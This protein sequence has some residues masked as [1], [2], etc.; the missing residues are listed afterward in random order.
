METANKTYQH[1]DYL[2]DDNQ[3]ASLEGDEVALL[4]YRSN[5]LGSDLT[6]YQLRR[7]QYQLQNYRTRSS[8]PAGHRSNVDQGIGR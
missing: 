6:N 2:W 8:Y 4:L 3:A 7:R 1:V 5:L